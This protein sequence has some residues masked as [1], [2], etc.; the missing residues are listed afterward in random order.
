MEWNPKILNLASRPIQSKFQS[1]DH[2]Q[3]RRLHGL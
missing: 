1:G 2:K 3:N